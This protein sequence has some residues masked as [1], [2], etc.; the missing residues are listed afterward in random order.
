MIQC[1]YLFQLQ[2]SVSNVL[3]IPVKSNFTWK[4]SFPPYSQ[5]IFW[6]HAKE[7]SSLHSNCSLYLT[8]SNFKFKAERRCSAN[9]TP[10]ICLV[11]G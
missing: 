4:N 7:E 5:R 1:S 11:I 3:S 10:W 2:F 6:M 9:R 8:D